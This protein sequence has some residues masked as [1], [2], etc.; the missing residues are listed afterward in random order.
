[1]YQSEPRTISSG[2]KVEVADSSAAGFKRAVAELLFELL[3]KS[4]CHP[5]PWNDANVA[6]GKDDMDCD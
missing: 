3:S 5:E 4:T 2:M 6:T 1:M